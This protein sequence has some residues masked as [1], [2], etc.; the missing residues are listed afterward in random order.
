MSYSQAQRRLRAVLA[1]AVAGGI[2][3]ASLI[4]QVLG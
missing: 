4:A 3:P 2:K 1:G